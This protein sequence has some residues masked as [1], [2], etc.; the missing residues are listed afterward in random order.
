[1]P[2]VRRRGTIPPRRQTYTVR[3]RRGLF[4]GIFGRRNRVVYP[5]NSYGTTY[6]TTPYSYT[7][8]GYNTVYT[9]PGTYIYSTSP[10]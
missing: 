8:T 9:T 1:M 10:Y 7:T 2:R 5:A 4:G 6:T 3:Q